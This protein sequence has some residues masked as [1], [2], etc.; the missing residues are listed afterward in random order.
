[1]SPVLRR[2]LSRLEKLVTA[3]R[4]QK[5]PLELAWRRQAAR[6]HAIRLIVLIL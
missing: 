2:R 1:M 5:E 4:K 6:D 3:E